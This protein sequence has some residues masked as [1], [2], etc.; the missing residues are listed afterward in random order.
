MEREFQIHRT[1]RDYALA[2]FW[3]WTIALLIGVVMG[4]IGFIVD[5]G[6]ELLNTFKYTSTATVIQ[7]HGM[8][9]SLTSTG[10]ISL[11]Q[12]E[13]LKNLQVNVILYS[14]PVG[15]CCA[16][17]ADQACRKSPCR[18]IA[19][20]VSLCSASRKHVSGFESLAGQVL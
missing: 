5:L 15:F 10:V 6:I 7:Q 17:D 18:L 9:L 2:E 16:S 8:S 20:S 19:I 11:M 3:K 1:E 13:L 4:C 12:G 14:Q